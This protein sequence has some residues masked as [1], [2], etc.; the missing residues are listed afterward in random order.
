MAHPRESHL[1]GHSSRRHVGGPYRTVDG[2]RATTNEDTKA[3]TRTHP[4]RRDATR[5]EGRRARAS[6]SHSR[7]LGR[8]ERATGDGDGFVRGIDDGARDAAV[9]VAVA[10]RASSRTRRARRCPGEER[11]RTRTTPAS[12]RGIGR[13]GGAVDAHGCERDRTFER[14]GAFEIRRGITGDDFD[15]GAQERSRPLRAIR[16]HARGTGGENDVQRRR[17][18]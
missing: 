10:R 7:A 12:R 2:A 11:A 6:S 8:G 18:R 15:G 1:G 13:R 5:V 9:V 4:R 14:A 3:S 17:W 16:A